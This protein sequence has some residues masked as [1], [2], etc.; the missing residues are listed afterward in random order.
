MI[1]QIGLSPTSH[2]SGVETSSC[3]L[4]GYVSSRLMKLA[5]EPPGLPVCIAAT[6]VDGYVLSLTPFSHSYN[7][8]S[9]VLQ[10]IATV[11]E[12]AEEKLWA[13]KLITDSVVPERWGN[14]RTPPNGAE[15]QSTKV[16][17]VEITS[18]GAKVRNGGPKEDRKDLK[19]QDLVDKVWTGVVPVHETFGK[20]VPSGHNRVQKIPEYLR[21][22]L[23][24]RNKESEAFSIEAAGKGDPFRERKNED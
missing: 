15:M 5:S 11:V 2:S 23:E 13:L 19:T 4:H 6:K 9:A 20:P 3:Y 18:A 1:G 12:D 16:L 21:G 14:T 22:F 7:Y 10:G 17:K 24:Q 8:R